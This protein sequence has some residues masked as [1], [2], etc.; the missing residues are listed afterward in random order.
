MLD[1]DTGEQVEA[2]YKMIEVKGGKRI[3][4]FKTTDLNCA[5]KFH[6]WYVNRYKQGL[7]MEIIPEKKNYD[8]KGKKVTYTFE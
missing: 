8:W 4:K 1:I 6:K 5:L 7:L 3:E 2:L